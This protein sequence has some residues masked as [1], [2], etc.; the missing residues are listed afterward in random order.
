M[1]EKLRQYL[2]FYGDHY[3]P[4]GGFNDL[5][6]S[7][8][9]LKEAKDYLKNLRS[10]ESKYAHTWGNVVDKD[11]GEELFDIDDKEGE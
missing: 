11:T 4:A 1:K 8:A 6:S 2:V 10:L 9:V 5:K 3:Y 7:F